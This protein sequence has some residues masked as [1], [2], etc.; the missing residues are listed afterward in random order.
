MLGR[1]SL[2]ARAVDHCKVGNKAI[3]RLALWAA[4][5]VT[6]EKVVP[7]QLCHHAHI[8]RQLR[9]SSAHQVLHIVVTALHMGD[10]VFIERIK[11]LRA[12][13]G[14]VFPPD[15]V[16]HRGGFDNMFVFGRTAR[17]LSGGHK[18]CP[19][20][21]QCAFACFQRGFDKRGFHQ[22]VVNSAKPCDTLIV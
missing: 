3:E 16:S 18:E 19:A 2:E 20:L 17:K 15:C 21:A 5:Q 8:D 1:V 4:Q 13:L 7:R 10:H 9:I 22:V 6:D 14:V 12:H 11:P